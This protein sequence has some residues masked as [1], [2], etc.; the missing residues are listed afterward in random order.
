MLHDL[1]GIFFPKLCIGCNRTLLK[2]EEY[3]CS[4]CNYHL[5]V[6]NYHLLKNNPLEK[7]FWGRVQIEKAFSFLFFKKGNIT[8]H[9][10]HELKY[11][12]NKELGIFLGNIYGE[13]LQ[14]HIGDID[15]VV[16]IPLHK[17]KLI[18]RGYNQSDFFASGLS[19]QLKLEDLSAFIYK[20]KANETQ[21]KKSRYERWENVEQIFE[22]TNKEI[23]KNKH[24]LIVDDVITT[25]ATIEA[26][27]QTLVNVANCKVS[28]ASIAI[29]L[30]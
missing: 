30:L 16:S 20:T 2:N 15:C 17:S 23:Y 14:K 8:Q 28:V 29:T 26:C 7:T 1:L 3:I 4:S 25:G 5:P 18:K 22:L 6:T 11:K 13:K 21:T 27:A 12:G 10:L 24:V 19:S 9:L